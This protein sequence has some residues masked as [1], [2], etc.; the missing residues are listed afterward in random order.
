M[1][2]AALVVAIVAA[3]A[4]VAAVVYARRLDGRAGEAVAAARKSAE[5]AERSAVAS[6]SRAAIE[7]Q[8][9][10]A[11]L[12]PRLQ[13]S[14]ANGSRDG[15]DLRLTVFLD[16]PSELGRLDSLTVLIRDSY[17]GGPGGPYRLLAM[18]PDG[19]GTV[20]TGLMMPDGVPVGES[21]VFELTP[22]MPQ[23]AGFWDRALAGSVVRLRLE[24]VG[25]GHESW[26]LPCE[27]DVASLPVTVEVP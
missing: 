27:V 26:S 10:H 5:A 17:P 13:V 7:G 3:L 12:T 15:G 25:H 2:V 4:A 1:N 22:A 11:E 21:L 8:R 16:G 20:T 24:C 18:G 19:Q 9:R 23:S 14:V 6:E